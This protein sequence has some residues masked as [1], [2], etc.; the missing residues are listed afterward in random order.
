MQVQRTL[1]LGRRILGTVWAMLLVFLVL[2]LPAHAAIVSEDGAVFAQLSG[3][4]AIGCLYAGRRRWAR[5]IVRKAGRSAAALPVGASPG[6]VEAPSALA[7]SP[8][9]PTA[10]A[11]SRIRRRRANR[12]PAAGPVAPVGPLGTDSRV[13]ASGTL[14]PSPSS[15][16]STP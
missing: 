14:R 5:R 8:V 10:G 9:A 7:S 11:I 16:Q 13:P 2:S 12:L 15:P 1:K 4:I 6:A 3:A